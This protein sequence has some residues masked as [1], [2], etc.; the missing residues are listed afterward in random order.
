MCPEG[1]RE[2]MFKQEAIADLGVGMALAG[3][4]ED[5]VSATEEAIG[6][7]MEEWELQALNEQ[8][9]ILSLENRVMWP[10]VGGA[11]KDGACHGDEQMT[12]EA[13]VCER[14]QQLLRDEQDRLAEQ[15][16]VN[17]MLQLLQAQGH[18]VPL[19]CT[20]PPSACSKR[21]SSPRTMEDPAFC[22]AARECQPNRDIDTVNFHL[23]S[24]GNHKG[25][26]CN[27]ANSDHDR[28]SPPLSN[29]GC[30]PVLASSGKST[31]WPSRTDRPSTAT[32]EK[33]PASAVTT[34]RSSSAMS[35]GR[36]LSPLQLLVLTQDSSDGVDLG[37]ESDDWGGLLEQST[38]RPLSGVSNLSGLSVDMS[39]DSNGPLDQP[40]ER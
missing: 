12:Q 36:P 32:S 23:L 27:A 25:W 39:T 9:E 16:R 29:S 22:L 34:S 14:E 5:G 2:S 35:L 38:L 6:E 7:E 37:F 33:R 20:P 19:L 18:T 31:R 4:E 40:H 13:H 24:M 3:A 17:Q 11:D 28:D 15:L 26:G 10:H 1:A 30:W 21:S 8:N